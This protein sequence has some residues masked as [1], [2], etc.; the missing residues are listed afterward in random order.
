MLKIKMSFYETIVSQF[1]SYYKTNAKKFFKDAKS[2]TGS[3]KAHGSGAQ[4]FLAF[5][6][7]L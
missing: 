1:D 2:L 5:F 3:R 4:I 6:A 7:V